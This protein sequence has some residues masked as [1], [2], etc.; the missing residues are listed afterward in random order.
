LTSVTIPDS[1]TL[2]RK[3]AFYMC[4]SLT[5]VYCK[6]TTPPIGGSNMFYY[7]ASIR[8]IYVPTSSASAYKSAE[9]W[10]DYA[11]D[12]VGYDF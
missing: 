6:P 4:N 9:Y 8:K 3:E 1:V 7:N 12:I 11:S 2:I 5:S 10:S